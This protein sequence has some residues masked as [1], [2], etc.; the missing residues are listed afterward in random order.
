MTVACSTLA[1]DVD[2]GESGGAGGVRELSILS[3]QFFC[4]PKNKSIEEKKLLSL[5]VVVRIIK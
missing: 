1:G 3:A 5:N 4:E 2:G